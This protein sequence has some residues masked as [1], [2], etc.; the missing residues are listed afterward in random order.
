MLAAIEQGYVQREIQQAAF[1]FQRAVEDER[2]IVVGVNK[3]QVEEE[4]PIPVLRIDP[5]LERAQVER[6]RAMR[7]RRDARAATAALDA[8]ESAAQG[9][10]NLMPLIVEAVERY[11]TVGE[12]SDRLRKVFGEY[13]ESV[14]F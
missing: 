10:E 5:E 11:A 12:I 3:F 8:I 9:T 1:D 7:A 13:R 4:A 6:L 14:V 2:A